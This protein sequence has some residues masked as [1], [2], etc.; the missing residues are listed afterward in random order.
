MHFVARNYNT[1]NLVQARILAVV[2]NI[3]TLEHSP[4]WD[5]LTFKSDYKRQIRTSAPY[6]ANF[7][8]SEFIIPSYSILH[9][10]EIV[11]FLFSQLTLLVLS[12]I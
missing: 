1:M 3:T 11:V 12:R 5:F 2:S 7:N 9:M 4:T 10:L 6:A 8:D